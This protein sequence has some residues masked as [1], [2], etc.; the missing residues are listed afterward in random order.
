MQRSTFPPPPD[1][2]GT[3]GRRYLTTNAD[4]AVGVL[5][6]HTCFR[7]LYP[8]H[9]QARRALL[10]TA[11][12]VARGLLHLH[13]TVRG[14]GWV[15]RWMT[16]Y[17]LVVIAAVRPATKPTPTQTEALRYAALLSIKTVP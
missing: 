8:H 14:R 13:D 11:A 16:A 7:S 2:Y 15:R 5:Y 6:T 9:A 17:M 1:Y 4:R 10:R 3:H 12:E